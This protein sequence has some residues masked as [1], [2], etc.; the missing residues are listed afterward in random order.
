MVSTSTTV[1]AAMESLLGS[2]DGHNCQSP[3]SDRI[4]EL[5]SLLRTGSI[6]NRLT[7]YDKCPAR[8]TE[9]KEEM[10]TPRVLDREIG[11]AQCPKPEPR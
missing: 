1:D 2:I 5:V 11:A 8:M 10:R 4:H 6:N 9:R 3:S 7:G